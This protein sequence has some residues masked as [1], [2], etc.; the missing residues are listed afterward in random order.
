MEWIIKGLENDP[1]FHGINSIV[2][3]SLPHLK[4]G[5]MRDF[6]NILK[7]DN[8]YFRE[9]HNKTDSLYQINDCY[10][11]FFSV[12][13]HDKLRGARRSN[14]FINEANNVSKNAYDQLETRT[15]NN[16]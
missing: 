8:I 16:V 12:D 11:E 4:R 9:Y 13:Q 6:F 10:Y 14:L 15:K 7:E 2:A 3:E 1:L 5:A